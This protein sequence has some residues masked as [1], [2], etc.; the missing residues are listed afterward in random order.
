MV[1]ERE[2]VFVMSKLKNSSACSL[3]LKLNIIIIGTLQILRNKYPPRNGK[4]LC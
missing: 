3:F 1:L 2:A 4:N